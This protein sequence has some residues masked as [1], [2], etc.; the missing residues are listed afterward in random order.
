MNS[1]WCVSFEAVGPFADAPFKDSDFYPASR[2]TPDEHSARQQIEGLRQLAVRDGSVRN[3]RLA[4][5]QDIE[6]EEVPV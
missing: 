2:E 4:I 6:W 3:I 5:A 1:R